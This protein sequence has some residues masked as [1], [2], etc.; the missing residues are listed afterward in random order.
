VGNGYSRGRWRSVD[1]IIFFVIICVF[2]I[3]FPVSDYPIFPEKRQERELGWQSL[4]AHSDIE[5]RSGRFG[6]S[7]TISLW[8]LKVRPYALHC[9]AFALFNS[10]SLPLTD[11][12]YR[13]HSATACRLAS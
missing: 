13:S 6:R 2:V 4:S 9:A 12:T 5:P 3:I 7:I 11:N 8:R 1:S 10:L